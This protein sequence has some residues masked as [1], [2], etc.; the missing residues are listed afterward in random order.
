MKF[1]DLLADWLVEL[2]YTHCFFLAGGNIMHLLESCSRRFTCIPVVHE[3]AAGIA[4]EYFNEVAD[5]G[6]AFALVT[7]GPGLTNIVG[8]RRSLS[9][10]P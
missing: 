4:T 1:G 10:K 6:K 2:G 3:V 5:G 8:Y 9:R 7:A